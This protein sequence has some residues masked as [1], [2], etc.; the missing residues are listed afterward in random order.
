ML[1]SQERQLPCGEGNHQSLRQVGLLHAAAAFP[2]DEETRAWAA[3]AV[4][5]GGWHALNDF[6]SNGVLFENSP[7][8]HAFETWHGR[9]LLMLA[10]RLGVTMEATA[11]DRFRQAAR[12]LASYRR[13]DGRLLV[14]N[15]AYPLEP[16]PLL[17]S[18]GIAV[19]EMPKTTLLEQGGLAVWRSPQFYAALDVS[20]FTG[21][22]SH[23]HGGKNAIVLFKGT[24]AI[25]D[26][27]GCCN[28]D[29]PRF[30]Q[31]KQAECHSSLVVDGA[32]DSHNFS[33][34]GFDTY[35]TMQF[36][37]WQGDV[38]Q[39]RMTSTTPEW[40]DVAWT[41]SI[42]CAVDRVELTDTIEAEKP[43]EYSLQF[44]LAPEVRAEVRNNSQ[45]ILHKGV[46]NITMNLSANAPFE[47]DVVPGENFQTD[48]ALPIQQ[49]RVVFNNV[50]NLH[51]TTVFA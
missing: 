1:F 27:P 46:M 29:D 45:V 25:L 21:E 44:T 9:D 19:S 2:V 24:E 20:A 4:E 41:R 12:V 15:D 42:Q 5:R 48:P 35:S 30:R 49:L 10:E 40:K 37:A 23:Y 43:H 36:G 32:P 14:F 11:A 31:C 22:F 51:L 47:L 13:P 38:F 28:Y 6:H 50:Q 39:S 16:D 7:S 3:F 18:L 26:D 33:L 8:Y 34:Y 17:D